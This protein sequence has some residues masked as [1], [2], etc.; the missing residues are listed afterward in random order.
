MYDTKSHRSE[1][2]TDGYGAAADRADVSISDAVGRVCWQS[3][4]PPS[5][6]SHL[7]GGRFTSTQKVVRFKLKL[8][9]PVR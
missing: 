3:Y 6:R 1:S 9:I 8:T 2:D 5:D 7:K 4:I